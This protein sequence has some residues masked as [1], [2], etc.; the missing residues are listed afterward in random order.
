MLFT[1]EEH[2]RIS[3]AIAAAE[4]KTSG[5]IFTIV[6]A[7]APRYH[8]MTFIIA[9]LLAFLSP[10]LLAAL[11]L[12][13]LAVLKLGTG[14]WESGNASPTTLRDEMFAYSAVQLLLFL[15]AATVIGATALER[16]LTPRG[17][18]AARA[19]KAAV[20]QFLAKGMHMTRER[21]G[22]LIYVALAD[23]QVEVVADEGIYT[24]APPETWNEAAAALVKG[25]RE[26][27]AAD[28]FVDAIELAGAA[29]AQHFPPR[30]DNP[31][32]LPDRLVEL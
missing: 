5:E 26:G 16:W 2:A 19:R 13:P 24:K 10:P 6:D 1:S 32:E 14:G 29:L 8:H 9:A 25:L 7:E 27:R 22:V 15:I 12:D 30:A 3:G 11:G 21:T 17:M 31:N 4:A 20:E 28:G 23:H 18:K